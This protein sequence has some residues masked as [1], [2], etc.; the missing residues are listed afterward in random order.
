MAVENDTSLWQWASG[1]VLS[2]V[3][4]LFGYHKYIDG[5]LAK[6][7]D[8]TA[9][10]ATSAEMREEFKTHRSYFAKVFDQMRENEQ[11]AQD[12]HERVMDKLAEK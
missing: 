7:A 6:K 10:D 2:A 11:R 4:T 5:K 9:L 1:V 3:G 8:Q 12:R